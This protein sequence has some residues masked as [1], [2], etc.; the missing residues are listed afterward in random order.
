MID[1]WKEF[2]LKN[3]YLYLK[4]NVICFFI[5]FDM[6]LP[7]KSKILLIKVWY[8]DNED[9]LIFKMTFNVYVWKKKLAVALAPIRMKLGE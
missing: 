2:F 4:K 9:I 8:S 5:A 6:F 7:I 1:I 3:M